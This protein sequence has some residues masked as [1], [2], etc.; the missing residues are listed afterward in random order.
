MNIIPA[1]D[2]RN[3]SCVRLH[4][5]DFGKQTEYS[6]RPC[7][8]ARDFE[9]LG[10]NRLHIVDLDGARSGT[11]AHQCVIAEIAARS[12]LAIQIGGG[13][14]DART[15]EA[16]LNAGATRCVVGSVAVTNPDMVRSW[17][18][19]FGVERIVLA[20]DVRIDSSDTPYLA[21]DGWTK[22]SGISLWECIDA[23]CDLQVRHILCT[24]I[25]RDGAMSGPNTPL[26][27]EFI[28]RYPAIELQASGGVRSIADL[29]SLRALG[30]SAA[31]TGRALLDGCI[32]S[33][34]IA[35]FLQNA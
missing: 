17:I 34:E 13:I 19:A 16:W 7:D 33:E 20:L 27:A 6:A 31:I 1:I 2:L 10:F 11:Q 14:R 21:T 30:A 12:S 29:E 25:S 15:L 32:A 5:G 9:K 8:V 23:Y 24:D 3:G 28:E 4:Q 35:A 22:T 18:S 26:Y